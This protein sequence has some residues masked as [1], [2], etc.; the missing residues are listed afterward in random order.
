MN[1]DAPNASKSGSG[2][3]FEPNGGF[4]G[5]SGPRFWRVWVRPPRRARELVRHD[6]SRL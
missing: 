6:G 3:P 2:K 4:S 5:M 1:S